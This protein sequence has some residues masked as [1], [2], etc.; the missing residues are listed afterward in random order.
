M[1]ITHTS[2][3]VKPDF[4]TRVKSTDSVGKPRHGHSLDCS[5]KRTSLRDN[6]LGR[7]LFQ[8]FAQRA[9]R[10]FFMSRNGH[11]PKSFWKLSH[12]F[13]THGPTQVTWATNA[14]TA[15]VTNHSPTTPRSGGMNALTSQHAMR[16]NRVDSSTF[17]KIA[18]GLR[19]ASRVPR[20]TPTRLE[21]FS[22]LHTSPP[23]VFPEIKS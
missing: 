23:L 3:A 18:S 12:D 6:R 8:R 17:Y 11:F 1:T 9:S 5:P 21:A 10:P 19:T 22:N 15:R 7:P 4:S 14:H 13:T 16:I 2:N 20:V